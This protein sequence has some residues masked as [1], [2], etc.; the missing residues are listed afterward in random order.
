VLPASPVCRYLSIGS[1]GSSVGELLQEV[2]SNLY[3]D[4]VAAK[5]AGWEDSFFCTEKNCCLIAHD[6]DDPD[7]FDLPML[8]IIIDV[9]S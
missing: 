5:A 1:R 7:P 3:F 4:G 6:C 2:T 9:I 8:F